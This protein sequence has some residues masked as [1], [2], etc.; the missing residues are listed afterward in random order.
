[1]SINRIIITDPAHLNA[2]LR[3]EAKRDQARSFAIAWCRLMDVLS[4]MLALSTPPG[5]KRTAFIHKDTLDD[6][7]FYWA[8]LEEDDQEAGG[9]TAT[10]YNGGL[11]FHRSDASWGIHT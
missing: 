9:N 5:R 3:L 8:I 10:I 1:M 6:G 11:I 2:V 4:G 7:C